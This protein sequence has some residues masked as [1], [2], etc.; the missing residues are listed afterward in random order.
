MC[1]GSVMEIFLCIVKHLNILVLC[2][3]CSVTYV[4]PL[5]GVKFIEYSAGVYSVYSSVVPGAGHCNY[6][7]ILLLNYYV[8]GWIYFVLLC[9]VILCFY[10]IFNTL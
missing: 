4:V 9:R 5:V 7:T 3:V 8:I 2:N 1:R 6:F 10:L